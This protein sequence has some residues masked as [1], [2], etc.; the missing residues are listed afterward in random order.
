M[1]PETISLIETSF[2][3]LG[4]R[5]AELTPVFYERLFEAAPGVRPLFPEDISKQA[6]KL[7]DTLSVVVRHI[8]ALDTVAP[9]LMEM[10]ARHARYGAIPEHYPVVRDTL[11][12]A[13][14][15]L[16]GDA[17][18]QQTED[19]WFE[20]LTLISDTMLSGVSSR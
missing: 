5:A 17:W 6:M 13:L 11:L 8:R 18:D 19:A 14:A 3:A 1:T 20:A 9:A 7:A 16:S 4:P 15:E 2:Q 12:G 10:G